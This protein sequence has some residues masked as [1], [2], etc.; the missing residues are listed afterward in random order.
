MQGQL[1]DLNMNSLF[2]L[3]ILSNHIQPL[4]SKG[5]KSHEY[6]A[7]L[8]GKVK[9]TIKKSLGIKMTKVLYMLNDKHNF[10]RDRQ[11]KSQPNHKIPLQNWER[12]LPTL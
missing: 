11:Q 5:F 2:I 6:V 1:F 7:L 3:S 8:G 9:E 4:I 10:Q 12:Y